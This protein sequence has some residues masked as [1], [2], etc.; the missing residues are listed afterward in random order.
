MPRILLLTLLLALNSITLLRAQSY[1]LKTYGTTQSE[2]GTSLLA[3][4]DSGYILLG[5]CFLTPSR[6]A[7][8]V[9]RTDRRGDTLWISTLL[10]DTTNVPVKLLPTEDDGAFVLANCWSDNWN[11]AYMALLRMNSD[12]TVRWCRKIDASAND[13]ANDMVRSGNELV[14]LSTT[15]YNLGTYPG[16]LLTGLDTAGN[17]LWSQHHLGNL[18]TLPGGIAVQDD[19]SLAVVASQNGFGTGTPSFYNGLLLLLHPDGTLRSSVSFGTYYDEDWLRIAAVPGGGWVVSGKAYFINHEWDGMLFHFDADGGLLNNRVYDAGTNNGE[20][21]RNLLIEPNGNLVVIGDKGTFDERNIFLTRID[22]QLQPFITNEYPFSVNFTNYPFEVKVTTDD[23]YAITGDMRPPSW[24]RDIFLLKIDRNG[25]APCQT[26]GFD[27]TTR[28]ETLEVT[29]AATTPGNAVPVLTAVATLRIRPLLR[30]QVVCESHQPLAVFS[31]SPDDS[32]SLCFDFTD[33][34]I[35]QPTSWSWEFPGA[36][37]STSDQQAPTGICY[38]EA[39]EYTVRLT[40]ANATGTSVAE[41]SISIDACDVWFIPNVI[42][43]GTDG[44]NDRFVIKGL[45]EPYELKIF[46]RWGNEVF[47]SQ[48][49]AST[50]A[51]EGRQDGN[52]SA[53]VYF[54]ELKVVSGKNAGLYHGTIEVLPED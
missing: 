39:G 10:V 36:T 28:S 42:T 7:L 12:G 25:R 33:N 29:A 4:P 54:Y 9:V 8:E 27:F 31:E 37:P 35:N 13:L 41:R 21:F 49:L 26:V 11:D 38:P 43:P 50:W 51:G 32:C 47:R 3:M 20:I 48:E 53:G 18:M 16:M 34:S 46:N 52:V 5:T 6:I 15:D 14:L 19:G 30:Q 1:F 22:P 17:L 23:G 40:I 45:K 2:Y 24:Y 44:K